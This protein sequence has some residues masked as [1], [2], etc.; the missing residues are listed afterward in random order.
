MFMMLRFKITN[1]KYVLIAVWMLTI[2]DVTGDGIDEIIYGDSQ[3]GEI[4][5]IDAMTQVQLWQINNPDHGV[6]G[7]AV[8]DVNN[9]GQPDVVWSSDHIFTA[10]ISNQSISWQSLDVTGPFYGIAIDDIDN[11]GINELVSVSNSSENN[12]AGIISIFNVE[13]HELEW[14]S[15]P[16]FFTNVWTNIWG[17]KIADIDN[18]GNKEI[19]ICTGKVYTGAIYIID[20]VTKSIESSHVYRS[21]HFSEFYMFEVADVDNDN[22]VDIVVQCEDSIYVIDPLTFSRKWSSV[23]LEGTTSYMIRSLIAGNVTSASNKQ[24]VLT[25][26][27]L[28]ILD[29]V[30]NQHW[31][32]TGK[33]YAATLYDFDN[34]GLKEIV[35]GN[36]SGNVSIING[37]THQEISSF[38]LIKSRIDGIVIGDLNNDNVPEYIFTSNGTVYFYVDSL[39]HLYTENYGSWDVGLFNSL[40]IADAD[41]NG[42]VEV[43]FGSQ[44]SLIELSY[45]CYH[46]L[47]FN[48]ETHLTN[49]ICQ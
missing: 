24:I 13:T 17:C 29:P 40:T 12:D 47:W 18:D 28:H 3:W 49:N 16:T 9:D 7:V 26:Q 45:E 32:S 4:H 38:R 33:Y 23:S 46:C 41:S 11:D 10:D 39:S 15:T 1:I 2:H 5:C 21:E 43:Y 19:I 31:K 30:S 37:I 44:V 25:R 22:Y 34:D 42:N 6:F 27:Y 14:Q 36:D 8:D 20:G 35:A 48:N